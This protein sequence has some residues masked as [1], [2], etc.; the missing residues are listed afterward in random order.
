MDSFPILLF[1]F[2]DFIS[3]INSG[4]LSMFLRSRYTTSLFDLITTAILITV[5]SLSYCIYQVILVYIMRKRKANGEASPAYRQRLRPV[6]GSG[7]RSRVAPVSSLMWY[8]AAK[9]REPGMRWP[10]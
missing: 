4:K 2:M 1:T 8:S 10:P 3:R 5:F 7:W 6:S 9:M